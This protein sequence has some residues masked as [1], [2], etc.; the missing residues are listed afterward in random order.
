MGG[1]ISVKS[2]LGKGSIFIIE[3]PTDLVMS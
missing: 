2:I 3:L 1:H